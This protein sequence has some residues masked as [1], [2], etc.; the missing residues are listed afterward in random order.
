ME[1]S[2]LRYTGRACEGQHKILLEL[3]ECSREGAH[4]SLA[5]APGWTPS[6]WCLLGETS[7]TIVGKEKIILRRQ[8]RKLSKRESS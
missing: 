6:P 5:V 7:F 4:Q 1:D 2:K 3:S 8:E